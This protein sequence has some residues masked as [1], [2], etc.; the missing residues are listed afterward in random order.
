MIGRFPLLHLRF[1]LWKG[2]IRSLG[3]RNLM[4]ALAL[5]GAG[6]LFLAIE[7]LIFYRLFDTLFRRIDPSLLIISRALSLHLLQLVFLVFG[8]ML[9]YSNLVTSISVFLSSSDMKLL[10]V[11]PIR[12]INLYVSKLLETILRSSTVLAVFVLPVLL[13]YGHARGAPWGYYAWLPFLVGFFLIIPAS[14]AIPVMLILARLVPTKRLQQG[15]IALG[16]L[17][18]T[19]ALFAFRLLRI[20]DA[21]MQAGSADQLVRWAATFRLPDWSWSPGSWLVNAIDKMLETGSVA[22]A[23]P[24]VGRLVGFGMLFLVV[25]TLVG[26][27]ILR[28]TWSRSFGVPRRSMGRSRWLR[29]G[30]FG[31]SFLPRS[32]AAIVLKEMKV[33]GRDLSRWS[34]IVMMIPLIGFYVLNMHL[35]PFKDQFREVYFLLNLFMIAFLQAAIGARYLFPSIRWEGPALWLIRVSPYSIGRMVAI[36]FIFL[37]LPL[38]LLTVLLAAFSFWALEF[39]WAV[40]VPSLWMALATTILLAGLAV[41]FGALLPRFQYEHHLEISLGPGGI[42]Y[43]LTALSVSFVY[44]MLLGWP[45]F[46]G[47]QSVWDIATWDFS[48][49]SP[50]TDNLR[51]GWLG[52]CCIATILSLWLGSYSLSR[53]EAFD[54]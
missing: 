48:D 28:G 31:R 54:R 27:W 4:K 32:D 1:L 20:E 53:K 26:S 34:Q 6:F 47:I 25:S 21:M 5:T 16:L 9:V 37:T 15:L 22:P 33:F 10:L 39:D 2:A 42:L 43:M 8:G 49:L 46:A 12:S 23:L 44:V 13:T 24:W 40:F 29:F 38:L 17:V 35:L 50:P 30:A 7:T 52:F 51:N 19:G 36:K 14:L 18:T 41:T 11:W 45:T 3:G